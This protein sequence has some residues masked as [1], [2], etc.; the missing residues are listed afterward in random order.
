[1][2]PQAECLT[3]GFLKAC[4]QQALRIQGLI[5]GQSVV[6]PAVSRVSGFLRR[7]SDRKTAA[8]GDRNTQR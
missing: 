6:A 8:S 1:M 3:C 2:Q 5:G 4:L 7:W